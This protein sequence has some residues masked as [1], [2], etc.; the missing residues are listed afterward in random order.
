MMRQLRRPGSSGAKTVE[1]MAINTLKRLLR[2]SIVMGHP[3]LAPMI[4]DGYR[5]YR[6]AGG[7]IYLNVKESGMMLARALGMY[8]IDQTDAI[9]S[10]L[11]P[12]LIFVD[13]GANKG[14]FSLLAA[15]AVGAGGSVLAFEPE[16]DNCR[17]IRKSVTLN[18]YENIS[19]YEFALSSANGAAQLYLGRHSGWHTLLPGHPHR[20]RGVIDVTTR[21]L[22][23]VLQ[24]ATDG[25]AYMLKIDVEGAEFEVLKGACDTLS[26][27][28]DIIVLLDL[29]PELGVDP[30]EVCEYLNGFGLRTYRLRP[31][32]NSRAR[33]DKGLRKVLARREGAG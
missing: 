6:F 16:P 26:N 27:N 13:V 31:P 33:L 11:G 32:F 10:L 21:T 9:R 12:G 29:H 5:P 24:E 8:D 15:S 17:W 7:R 30:V 14:D 18:G 28:I 25:V 2:T 3:M 1:R 22:D 20:N 19:L 23:S 4:P